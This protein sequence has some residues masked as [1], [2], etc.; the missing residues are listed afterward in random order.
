MPSDI[1]WASLSETRTN[2]DKIAVSV[3]EGKTVKCKKADHYWSAFLFFHPQ[4]KDASVSY[5]A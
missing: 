3:S 1:T 4:K 5:W 2:R